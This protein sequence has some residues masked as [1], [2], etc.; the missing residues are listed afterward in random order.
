MMKNVLLASLAVVALM[1][2]TPAIALQAEMERYQ[3]VIDLREMCN[4]GITQEIV[5][6]YQA[7]VAALD[8]TN[9]GAGRL[10]SSKTPIDAAQSSAAGTSTS[11]VESNFYGPIAPEL[12]LANCTGGGGE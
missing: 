2:A 7:A 12:A 11:N 4:T 5:Q 6:L 9:D 3:Q 10:A 8:A 1:A